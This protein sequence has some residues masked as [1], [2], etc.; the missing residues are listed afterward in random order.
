MPTVRDVVLVGPLAYAGLRPEEAFALSWESVTDHHVIVDRAFTYGE[1]KQ[2]KTH[3]RRVVDL[4]PPL[5]TDIALHRPR[6]TA[7]DELVLQTSTGLPVDLRNWRNRVWKPAA[8]KAGVAAT[9]YDLRHTYCSLLAHEG[10]AAVYIAAMMGHSTSRTHDRYSHVITDAHLQP[11]TP[12]ADAI[13]QAR[14]KLE[15]SGLHPSCT[16]AAPTILRRS[17]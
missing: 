15:G 10:R 4:A 11:L 8:K 5:A 9:P 14:P 13:T 17:L 1:M 12:M 16:E 6:V 2:T 7:P 3:L